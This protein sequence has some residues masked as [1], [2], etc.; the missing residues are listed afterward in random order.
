MGVQRCMVCY[1]STWVLDG[2]TIFCLML[3]ARGC[4]TGK[5]GV[6][7][8]NRKKDGKYQ[9]CS[10]CKKYVMC[11]GGKL[12]ERRCALDKVWDDKAKECTWWSTTCSW[13]NSAPG[14]PPKGR[15]Y[16]IKKQA[17]LDAIREV[18]PQMSMA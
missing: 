16:I 15:P 1:E 2:W 13:A 7:K 4:P 6:A 3:P 5:S 9:H 17:Y 12:S 18:P 14:P 11:R 10:S 8:C